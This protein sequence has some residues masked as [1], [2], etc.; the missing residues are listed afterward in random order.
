MSD[1]Y[2]APD[3]SKIRVLGPGLLVKVD[4]PPKKSASGLIHFAA[5]AMEHVNNKGTVVAVGRLRSDEVAV[6]LPIPGIK[7][8]DRIL[9]VRFLANQASNEQMQERIEDGLIRLNWTDVLVVYDPEDEE[10]FL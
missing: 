9:F 2:T 10:R 5:D 6:E 8:G 7:V 1:V 3:G 4:E